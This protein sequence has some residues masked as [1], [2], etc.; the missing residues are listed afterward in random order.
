MA[1]T[2]VVRMTPEA[3][4]WPTTW[5][6]PWLVTILCSRWWLAWGRLTGRKW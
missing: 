4:A 5:S 1:K 6:T 3:S 2:Q